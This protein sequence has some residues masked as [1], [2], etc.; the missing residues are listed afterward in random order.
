MIPLPFIFKVQEDLVR[1]EEPV[2]DVAVSQEFELRLS[3][4][5]DYSMV[6]PH[7]ILSLLEVP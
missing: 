3:E 1:L 7:L 4:K 6:F 5:C 2:H